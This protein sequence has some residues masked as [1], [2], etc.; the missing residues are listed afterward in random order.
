MQRASLDEKQITPFRLKTYISM[1][2]GINVG[3]QK[4]VNMGRL[5]ETYASLG[6][7]NVQTYVQ[8]GNVLFEYPDTDVSKLI[9]RIEEKIKRSFG[10]DVLVFIRTRN[11]LQKLI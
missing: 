7:G 3:G 11:E 10:F 1:L 8:S 9:N 5:R 2:R 4:K 6:F